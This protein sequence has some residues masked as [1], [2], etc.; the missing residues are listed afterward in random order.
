[1][2]ESQ[3]QSSKNELQNSKRKRPSLTN[4]EN[5]ANEA[6]KNAAFSKKKETKP[7]EFQD[8]IKSGEYYL[9]TNLLTLAQTDFVLALKIYPTSKRANIGLTKT[10]LRFCKQDKK[11]CKEATQ[12]YNKLMQ[13][14][15]LL[16]GEIKE[17]NLLTETSD[18]NR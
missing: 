18:N 7:L 12:Y 14:N 16:E 6:I 2:S 11:F 10:L 8:L 9:E 13:S 15:I 4:D 3:L 1:M 17:L 5:K